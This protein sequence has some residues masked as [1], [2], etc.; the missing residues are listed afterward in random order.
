MTYIVVKNQHVPTIIGTIM[1]S[2]FPNWSTGMIFTKIKARKL[3]A[4]IYLAVF[5]LFVLLTSA[6]GAKGKLFL[7]EEE[8][9]KQQQRKQEE[10]QKKKK[11]DTETETETITESTT[12]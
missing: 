6:C 5:I 7:P 4:G 10:E 3:K 2:F 11:A 9:A 12:N 1:P 8:E